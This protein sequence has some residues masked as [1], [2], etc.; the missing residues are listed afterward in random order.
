MLTPSDAWSCHARL[1]AGRTPPAVGTGDVEGDAAGAP[2]AGLGKPVLVFGGGLVPALVLY[3][4]LQ[5]ARGKPTGQGLL[6]VR[7][8][9]PFGSSVTLFY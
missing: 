3:G 8:G 5:A 4:D 7:G 1:V 6:D 9:K 2:E